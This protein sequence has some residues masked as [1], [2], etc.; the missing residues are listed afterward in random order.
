MRP[1]T[2]LAAAAA[3]L[4]LLALPSTAAAAD[5]ATLR[6][7]T[8]ERTV[9]GSRAP[10]VCSAR[11]YL[12]SAGAAHALAA[13]TAMGQLVSAT[14]WLGLALEVTF[15]DQL[16]GFVSAIGGVSGGTTGFWALYVDNQSSQVGAETATV[17]A[18][19]EVVWVLDPDF[20]Q[21]GPQFLDLD[22]V[23]ARGGVVVALVTRVGEQGAEPARGAT[24]RVNTVGESG[25]VT[26]R[27]RRGSPFT[28]QATQAGVIR[29]EVVS[30]RA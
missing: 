9:L 12:D 21:P 16:G 10:A 18:G 20:N 2:R 6:V 22:V 3:A 13:A 30:G 25:R 26:V 24:L 4:A 8:T 17:S 23:R 19:D 5:C 11:S 7:E 1:F 29:S 28:A 15:D 14:G 27:L